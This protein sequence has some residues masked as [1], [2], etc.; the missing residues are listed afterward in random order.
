MPTKKHNDNK[1]K[2]GSQAKTAII[3]SKKDSPK[4]NMAG[5]PQKSTKTVTGIITAGK[6]KKKQQ[7]LANDRPEG[8]A[9][10]K[11]IRQCR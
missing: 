1:N 9:P 11:S 8:G 6:E 2:P 3:P 5:G 4:R 7:N 10:K